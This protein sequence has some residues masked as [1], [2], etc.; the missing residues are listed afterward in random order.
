MTRVIYVDTS[1]LVRAALAEHDGEVQRQRMR[2]HLAA[3]DR[4]VSSKLLWLEAERVATRLEV[5]DGRDGEPVR[6]YV[7]GVSLLPLDDDVWR[8]AHAI[9]QHVRTL[10]A[11]HLATCALAGVE[12][13]TSDTQ[14][15]EVAGALGITCV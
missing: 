12:L 7:R 8:R 5:V 6:A 14:M 13:L 2:A 15:R 10:D 11:I 1:T 4:M 9:R 3:G